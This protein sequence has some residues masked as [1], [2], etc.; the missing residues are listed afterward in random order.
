MLAQQMDQTLKGLTSATPFEERKAILELAMKF[1]S[2]KLKAIGPRFGKGF[3]IDEEG[4]DD[5]EF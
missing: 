3:E 2:L 1:E 4:D 5:D